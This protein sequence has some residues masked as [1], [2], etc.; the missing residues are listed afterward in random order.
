MQPPFLGLAADV[1]SAPSERSTS[2]SMERI[3]CSKQAA[4]LRGPQYPMDAAVAQLRPKH[5]QI[6][7]LVAGEKLTYPD[8]AE[9]LGITVKCV[10][11]CFAD[12]LCELDRTLEAG[13][14]PPWRRLWQRA[15]RR[16]S[17]SDGHDSARRSLRQAQ[18]NL[19]TER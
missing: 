14:K 4:A 9:R 17:I 2:S 8:I 6:L 15:H 12:A 19:A 5:Q 18:A 16:G 10:E 13:G 11:R 7:V 3:V 1:S